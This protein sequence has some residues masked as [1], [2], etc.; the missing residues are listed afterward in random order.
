VLAIL[1]Q[2]VVNVTGHIFLLPYKQL[3]FHLED[4]Q[5]ELLMSP[6]SWALYIKCSWTN[7]ISFLWFQL[8]VS[9]WYQ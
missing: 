1:V 9:V 7:L 6:S 3:T 8:Y 5:R 2:A 4:E